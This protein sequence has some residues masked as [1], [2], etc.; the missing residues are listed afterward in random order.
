MI[1]IYILGLSLHTPN[2]FTHTPSPHP[3]SPRH[4]ATRHLDPLSPVHTTQVVTAESLT[5]S[6]AELEQRKQELDAQ[7]M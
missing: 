6:I 7:V 3:V 2:S 4:Y 1:Y 5:E